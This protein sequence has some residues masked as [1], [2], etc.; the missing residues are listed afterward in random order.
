M[1]GAHGSDITDRWAEA[2]MLKELMRKVW[3]GCQE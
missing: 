2:L 1:T 3:K